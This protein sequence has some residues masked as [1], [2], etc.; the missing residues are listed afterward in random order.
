MQTFAAPLYRLPRISASEVISD[1]LLCTESHRLATPTR[2]GERRGPDSN[3]VGSISE[4]QPL[5]R[6]RAGRNT[7]QPLPLTRSCGSLPPLRGPLARGSPRP[8]ATLTVIS[9]FPPRRRVMCPVPI[10]DI[11]G[12]G[13]P[14]STGPIVRAG[15]LLRSSPHP[16]VVWWTCADSNRSLRATACGI[17][18]DRR[19]P[20]PRVKPIVP[21]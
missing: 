6:A 12:R 19:L 7:R 3:R 8:L 9:V 4:G 18:P 15:L 1:R 5:L 21:C 14:G 20:R 13:Q 16:R 11:P 2:F 17:S 10:F